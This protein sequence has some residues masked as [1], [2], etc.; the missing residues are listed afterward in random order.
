MERL[1]PYRMLFTSQK[2]VEY[3]G[4]VKRE[5]LVKIQ[6]HTEV[7][8]NSNRYEELFGIVMSE[9]QVAGAIPVTSSTGALRTTALWG[10]IEGNPDTI[11]WQNEFIENVVSRLL[12]RR[13]IETLSSEIQRLARKRFS[14]ERVLEQWN[15]LFS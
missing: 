2:N 14:I 4:A 7:F 9:A 13:T 10:I 5:E 8:A 6:Q 1:M 15:L 11:E 3:R 12:D